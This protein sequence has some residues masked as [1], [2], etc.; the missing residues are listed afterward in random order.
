MKLTMDQ[1]I[2]G[3]VDI[4]E[5]SVADMAEFVDTEGLNVKVPKTGT[6]KRVILNKIVDAVESMGSTKQ[7]P[8]TETVS[9]DD[10]EQPASI[11]T[12]PAKPERPRRANGEII[13]LSKNGNDYGS[14]WLNRQGR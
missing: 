4:K 3:T 9:G 5:I 11:E 7:N 2:N 13:R 10:Q 1:I 8:V 6:A 12:A 14:N